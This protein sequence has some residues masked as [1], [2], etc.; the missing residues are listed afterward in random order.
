LFF[1]ETVQPLDWLLLPSSGDASVVKSIHHRVETLDFTGEE[2]FPWGSGLGESP[3]QSAERIC[4]SS[5][6]LGSDFS[7]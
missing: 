6:I 5:L 7:A 1:W 2:I 3:A 4:A